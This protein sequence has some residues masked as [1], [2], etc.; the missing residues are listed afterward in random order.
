MIIDAH[1]HIF[2]PQVIENL[3]TYLG[4]DAW[5]SY[6]FSRPRTRMRTAEQL[7]ASMD[8][9][10]IHRSV[11]CGF[12]WNDLSLCQMGNDYILE[13]VQAHPERFIGL[14]NVQPKAGRAAARE[15]ERCAAAGLR[16]I[17]ELMPSGQRFDLAD[18][19]TMTPLVEAA[20]DLGLPILVHTSEPV[21]HLY[22][23]KGTVTVE[24]VYQF[25]QN[26]PQATVV[27]GHWGGGLFLYE[28]MPK[29]RQALAN[30][31]YDTA[32]S[33]YLY[34]DA[35]LAVAMRI[36]PRKVMFG[37]DYPLVHQRQF[38]KRVRKS[39]LSAEELERILGGNARAVY[40]L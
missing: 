17:G 38:L 14:I 21:G 36:V 1:T 7:I 18:R 37:T 19:C 8:E 3:E 22:A 27:C 23:G 39:G 28:L 35:I 4:A 33:A 9:A 5:F 26:F 16:G 30:I 24:V 11:I 20:Q 12:C 29:V 40:K 34:D 15:V 10:G 25:A 13:A 6:L 31:Y 32:A 2:P